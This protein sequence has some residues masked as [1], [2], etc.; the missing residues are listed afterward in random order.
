M[1]YRSCQRDGTNE[2]RNFTS[3]KNQFA[4][5]YNG[6]RTCTMAGAVL[7]L[8]MRVFWVAALALPA[9]GAQAGVVFSRLHSFQDFPNGANPYAGLV[10]GSDGNFYGTTFN[11]GTNG[12]NGTVFKI[13]TNGALTSL[14]SFTSGDDGGHPVGGVVQ[15]SDGNFYGTTDLGGTNRVGTVFEVNSNGALTS[16]YSFSGGNDG[17]YPQ[18][19]LAHGSDGDFYGTTARG[20]TNGAGTVFKIG[21]NGALISLYS[22][23]GSNDGAYPIAGLVQGSDGSFYGTTQYGGTNKAGTVFKISTGG[24]LVSLHSF[25]G[26]NDGG[27]PAAGLA[28]GSDGNFYG[29]TVN[30][31]TYGYYGG[32]VFKISTN[33]A[34]SN[35]YSFTG[36][37]DGSQPYAGLV[38]D[39][40]GDFYG[41]TYAGGTNGNGTVF[42]VSTN[43]ALTSLY[44][45]TGG[46]DGEFPQSGLAHGS[47]GYFHGTTYGGG[48]N[49]NGTVFQISTNGALTSVYS[50]TGAPDGAN[51]PC[52]LVQA[53]DHDFYGTASRGGTNGYGT[54]FKMSTNGALASLYSFAGGNDGANPGAGLAE[55]SDGNFYGTTTRGGTNKAGTVFKISADGVLTNLYSFSGGNDGA[56]PQAG[57][58][59]GSDGDFHGTTYA[60]GATGYGTVFRIGTNGV[61]TSLYSF[62][63]SNDGANPYAGL[64][65]GSGGNFYG[66]TVNGGSNGFGTVFQ[67]G[68]NSGLGSLYSFS[69]GNDGANPYAG[70]VQGSGGNFYGTTVNGGTN[71]YGTVFLIGAN[72]ALASLYSFTG[73]ID[74]ANPEAALMRGSNG[75]FYGT[76]FNAGMNDA[77]TLFQ[78]GT[79][80]VLTSLYSFS[81][82]NNGAN[83]EAAL[84]QGSDGNFYGTTV[85][86]GQGGEG[87][88]FRVIPMRLAPVF[89]AVT[90]TNS[91]LSLTWSAEAGGM[92]QVQYNSDLS[93]SL[94]INLSNAATATGATL[95]A[96]DFVTNGPER[97]YRVVLLP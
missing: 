22:F 87:T 52:A 77:G 59:E 4:T 85:N 57:L 31:G 84:I 20:G 33:G 26:S 15:G 64:V 75:N 11:G 34:L 27:Y 73:G 54:V 9:F 16:L 7:P 95:S 25:T 36:N 69:G 28:Q 72:G 17:A 55:G 93:S 82:G 83:P 90:L 66:T 6:S 80:S 65:Q 97:F 68:T 60:G 1:A 32:T 88:V 70:L 61:L 18:A 38:Q 47:D 45:F 13:S 42:R 8:L 62:T 43:G 78:I 51:P 5:L 63:G 24:A 37:L 39:G 40:D 91:T 3:M 92:Y 30:D 58:V 79:N 10:Q 76:T 23:T 71:G 49:G 21:A 35:L 48:T 81:G 74:G 67:I 94:W 44:S 12:G 46:N 56:F 89:Q 14:Y 29:T 96:L 2:D 86:G 41:T 53:S 50:F 19:G